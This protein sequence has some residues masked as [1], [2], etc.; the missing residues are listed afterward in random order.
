MSF[1]WNDKHLYFLIFCFDREKYICEFDCKNSYRVL[2]CTSAL[3]APQSKGRWW[4]YDADPK[5]VYENYGVK[6]TTWFPIPSYEQLLITLIQHPMERTAH[7][8]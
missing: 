1:Q 5:H 6:D 4:H 2:F 3:M 8:G 7:E